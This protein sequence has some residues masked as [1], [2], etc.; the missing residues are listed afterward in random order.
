MLSFVEAQISKKQDTPVTENRDQEI[1]FGEN[2]WCAESTC[3]LQNVNSWGN[4]PFSWSLEREVTQKDPWFVF[5]WVFPIDQIFHYVGGE[6]T[7]LESMWLL[8]KR[9]L[10]V[11]SEI[12]AK[13]FS[14][15]KTLK[16]QGF[17]WSNTQSKEI[18]NPCQTRVRAENP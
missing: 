16:N 4:V 1:F 7:S 18:H 14:I 12:Q 17:T 9:I 5:H 6:R 15:E 11:Y 2:C 8:L 13:C 10:C 3:S